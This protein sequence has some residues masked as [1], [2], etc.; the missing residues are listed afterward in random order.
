MMKIQWLLLGSLLISPAYGE[1]EISY[2]PAS[3]KVHMPSV[4]VDGQPPDQGY[5]VEMERVGPNLFKVVKVKKK[6]PKIDIDPRVEKYLTIKRG[7]YGQ[8]TESSES[9]A[10]VYAKNFEVKI[11]PADITVVDDTPPV[12][13]GTT[14]RNGFFE[15]ALEE[16]EYQICT[17]NTLKT[18]APPWMCDKFGVFENNF[19]L[20]RRCDSSDSFGLRSWQCGDAEFE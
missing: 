15:I 8:V 6:N 4:L 3:G 20:L 11:Y 13:T 1:N 14:D 19:Q 17:K 12:A 16:G 18:D 9:D 7:V 2:D 5:E 10:P